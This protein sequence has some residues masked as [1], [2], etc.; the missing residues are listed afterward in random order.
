MKPVIKMLYNRPVI[1]AARTYDDLQYAFNNTAAPSVILFFGDILSL[2]RLIEQARQAQKRLIVHFDLLEGVGKDNV[3]V[4]F[5]ALSGVS[6]MITTKSHL[7]KI[8]RQEGLIVIQRIFLVDSEALRSGISILTKYQPDAVE[9]MPG[10]V[11]AAAVAE[12]VK[13][14]G[15]PVLGGGLIN[16]QEDVDQAIANGFTAV[17]TGNRLLW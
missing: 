12:L 17:S 1:P 13:A 6:A 10:V 5:L 4:K 16:T 7:A 15:L 11:P 8:G 9:V 3:G 14:T 2:P